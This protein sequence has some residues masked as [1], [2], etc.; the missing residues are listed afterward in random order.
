MSLSFAKLFDRVDKLMSL[1]PN[2]WLCCQ[3]NFTFLVMNLSTL[4]AVVFSGFL[5]QLLK[6]TSF[7]HPVIMKNYVLTNQKP[8]KLMIAF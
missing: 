8:H 1:L 5:C 7:F 3:I 2:C 4:R 6:T